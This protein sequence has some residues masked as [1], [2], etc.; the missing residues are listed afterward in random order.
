MQLSVRNV[1]RK[2]FKEFKSEAVSEGLNVGE[3]LTIAMEVWM[4]RKNPKKSFL[5][6][7]P[8]D[9]GKGTEK[10]SKEVDRI[11]R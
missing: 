7:R 8:V 5:E 4:S 10:A 3:A 2:V 6:L 11:Y 9:W 1:N